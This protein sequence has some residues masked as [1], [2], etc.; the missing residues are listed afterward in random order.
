MIVCDAGELDAEEMVAGAR[1]LVDDDAARREGFV[2]A[3]LHDEIHGIVDGTSREI[4]RH[5]HANARDTDVARVQH[6][7]KTG[8]HDLDFDP[9]AG[10]GSHPGM[11][12]LP[13][14]LAHHRDL[15]TTRL[16]RRPAH[17][18]PALRPAEGALLAG[19]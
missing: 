11:L 8:T 1:R 7:E 6:L 10:R 2:R 9:G 16:V 4:V 13:G 3:E 18:A 19:S 15:I 14:R 17:E 5:E 12:P